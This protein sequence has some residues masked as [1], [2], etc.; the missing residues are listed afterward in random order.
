MT[1]CGCAP[2]IPSAGLRAA[3]SRSG[4]MHRN[5]PSNSEIEEHGGDAAETPLAVRE[6]SADCRAFCRSSFE[7][8]RSGGKKTQK[9]NRGGWWGG[10]YDMIILNFSSVVF[11]RRLIVP[12]GGK[13]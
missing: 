5:F 9:K 8:D 13:V 6:H 1:N 12:P 7:P 11:R 2:H 10:R 4:I 3:G